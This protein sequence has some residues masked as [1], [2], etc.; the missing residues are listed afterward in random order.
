MSDK[1]FVSL[2]VSLIQK[3]LTIAD[4]GIPVCRPA[5]GSDPSDWVC[6]QYRDTWWPNATASGAKV[7]PYAQLGDWNTE[8]R[9]NH[10]HD[11]VPYLPNLMAG[12]DP[13]PWEEH[14]PSFAMPT[15]AEWEAV[16][17]AVVQQCQNTS[18]R[19]GWP[20]ASAPGGFQ[21]AFEVYAWN[22][23]AEGGILAPTVGQGYMKL[24]T[25]GKVLGRC[26]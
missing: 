22:E 5:P 24:R 18:N 10:S 9:T 26:G 12:W 15:E 11:L 25:I 16:V 14:A 7:F 20:D 23:F 13:R 2:S 8:S 4:G 17:R 1:S 3:S 19:F 21:P 6:P